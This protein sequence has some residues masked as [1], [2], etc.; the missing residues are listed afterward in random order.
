MDAADQRELELWRQHGLTADS[1]H[2][3]IGYFKVQRKKFAARF[4]KPEDIAWYDNR[5]AFLEW[6]LKQPRSNE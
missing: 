1:V 2:R 3:D 4:A 5:I 6:L